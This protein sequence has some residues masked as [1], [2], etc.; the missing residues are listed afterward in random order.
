[1]AL[2][3][4]P[5]D[6]AA[7]RSVVAACILD[8]EVLPLVAAEVGPEELFS[9]NIRKAYEAV[10][11]LYAD[12]T[13]VTH[14]TVADRMGGDRERAQRV[15]LDICEESRWVWSWRE[16]ARVLHG[17]ALRRRLLRAA[18]AIAD[19]ARE[20]GA[21]DI[22]E[23]AENAIMGV[24]EPQASLGWA[25]VAEAYTAALNDGSTDHR[26]VPSGYGDLDFLLQGGMGGGHLVILAARPSVGK[27]ALALNMAVKAARSGAAVAF[28]SLEMTTS[29]LS[30]RVMSSLSGV[31]LTEMRSGPDGARQSLSVAGALPL[32]ICDAPVM[33][34]L[35]VRSAAKTKLAR[36]P[37]RLVVVDYLQLMQGARSNAESRQVEVAQMSRALKVL[38]KEL[39]APVLALSQ[40][41]RNIEA[42][43]NKRPQLS[44]LRESGAIEQD[45]DVVMFL[46]RST[47]H[48][49][50][51]DPKR[52]N[53]G[54]ASLI[55]AKN[56]HGATGDVRLA[57]D[58]EHVR[59]QGLAS[60]HE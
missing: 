45:A 15:V 54:E 52:P 3:K 8:A 37:R 13:G 6:T 53:A 7:E 51:K 2:P 48:D 19:A 49:E 9:P 27:S 42:R 44:D 5:S 1:V 23:F 43:A 55:V 41:S 57:W 40:L 24:T 11:S 59:F 50:L 29:E 58:A 21:C 30:Y 22:A 12:G 18:E 14:I 26:R 35:Q 16:H 39:D 28:F 33:T 32:F 20:D 17:L 36:C 4:P 31:A 25:T 34:A 56:R 47:T 60:I 38:A 46:D 10:L